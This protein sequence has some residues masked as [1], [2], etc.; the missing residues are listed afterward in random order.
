MGKAAKEWQ[1]MATVRCE[2]GH[3]YDDRKHHYCPFCSVP[4]L[5][6]VTIPRT[7]AAP[8]SR[9]SVPQTEPASARDTGVPIRGGASADRGGA[10]GVTVGVVQKRTGIEHVVGWLVC[11]KG[12]NKGRDYR[13]HSDLNK[14]GRAPNMDVCVEGD[15]TISRENHCQIAFS[16]RSRTFSVI[17]GSGKNLIYRNGDD[18]LTATPLQAY[19]CLDLGESSFLFIPFCTDRFDWE[20]QVPGP[21]QPTE[22]DTVKPVRNFET[23]V[24]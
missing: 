21:A 20:A 6:N 11:I 1:H 15:E 18:V 2:N 22:T 5:K 12:I 3:N 13:L 10:S 19:D 9:P 4:G 23:K 14:L 24:D 7:E 16:P 17:P 8:M